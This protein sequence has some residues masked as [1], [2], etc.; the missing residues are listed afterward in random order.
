MKTSHLLAP[1]LRKRCSALSMA[2]ALVA[3][4]Q[5]V[6]AAGITEGTTYWKTNLVDTVIA[7]KPCPKTG[8]CGKIVW[9]NPQDQDAYDYFG[10][11]AKIH[12]RRMN[13]QD[14]QSLCGYSP[15]IDFKQVAPNQWTGTME[16]RGK[17]VTANMEATQI[18]E[19]ELRIRISKFI[20]SE[21]DTWKRVAKN[22]PRY[23]HCAG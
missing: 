20:F 16:V 22:D 3:T 8:V 17:G 21:T 12:G 5:A 11:P 13:T 10:D 2:F 23:P 15:K 9:I 14:I 7:L 4:P 18:S 19:N 6:Q 1:N